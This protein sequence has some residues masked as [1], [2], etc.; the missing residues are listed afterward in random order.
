M[1]RQLSSFTT[2]HANLDVRLL[3]VLALG[4]AAHFVPEHW[5]LG[6]R[7]RFVRL[8]AM[9]QGFALFCAAAAI[10]QMASAE[11]VPFVYFQF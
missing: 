10:R 5:Y 11:A 7:Q 2:H 8:P 1:F 3:A 4:L 9:A 6:L